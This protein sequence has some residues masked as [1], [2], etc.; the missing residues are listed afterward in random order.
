MRKLLA[1][2]WILILLFLFVPLTLSAQ[3]VVD[4]VDAPAI[5]APDASPEVDQAAPADVL[6]EAPAEVSR[7]E[8]AAAG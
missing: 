6:S 5:S 1:M 4:E 2:S 8:T 3:D 7:A